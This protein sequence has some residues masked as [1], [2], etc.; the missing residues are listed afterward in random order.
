MPGPRRARHA[1]LAAGLGRRA[2]NG[3]GRLP[4]VRP[5]ALGLAIDS[6]RQAT[7]RSLIT[8]AALPRTLSPAATRSGLVK[9]W[10]LASGHLSAATSRESPRVRPRRRERCV[11]PTSATNSR[12]EHPACLPIPVST[13]GFP[14]IP[15]SC[16]SVTSVRPGLPR[17]SA[18]GRLGLR[19][20]FPCR[21]ITG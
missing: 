13:P 7:S 3:P 2:A 6:E 1:V 21:R 14:R 20:A 9:D 11:S 5:S 16:D 19:S 10:W 18:T 4:S 15:Q 17:P 12:H 8:R